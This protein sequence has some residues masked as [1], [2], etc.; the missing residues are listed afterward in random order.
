MVSLNKKGLAIHGML[1]VW[2]LFVGCVCVI[3]LASFLDVNCIRVILL[4]AH[5]ITS[6]FALC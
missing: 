5:Y 4:A 2:V 6:C 1:F 3:L